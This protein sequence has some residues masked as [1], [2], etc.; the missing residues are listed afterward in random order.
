MKEEIDLE[1]ISEKYL[2]SHWVREFMTV[3]RM[4]ELE[5]REEENLLPPLPSIKLI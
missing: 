3:G 1:M 5:L 2:R 4:G